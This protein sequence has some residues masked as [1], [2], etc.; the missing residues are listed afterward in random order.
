MQLLEDFSSARKCWCT[1]NW[2][3][4]GTRMWSRLLIQILFILVI[5]QFSVFSCVCWPFWKR[6]PVL[7]LSPVMIVKKLADAKTCETWKFQYRPGWQWTPLQLTKM[8][9]RCKL[10]KLYFFYSIL[11]IFCFIYLHIFCFSFCS[12]Q[13]ISK[14]HLSIIL[15]R[16]NDL[17]APNLLRFGSFKVFQSVSVHRLLLFLL[18]L[19]YSISFCSM[20]SDFICFCCL[21][22]RLNLWSHAFPLRRL[23]EV[24]RGLAWTCLPSGFS[25]HTHIACVNL[26]QTKT[27]SFRQKNCFALITY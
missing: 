21:L 27:R 23:Q 3:P 20:R 9:W 19:F 25:N 8:V 12:K 7:P 13:K 16:S 17:P 11:H 26:N 6:S 22:F 1:Y 14:L 5:L 2:G 10:H 24:L 18:L 15:A 4:D